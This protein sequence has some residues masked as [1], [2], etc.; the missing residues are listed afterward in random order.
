MAVEIPHGQEAEF[1]RPSISM[2]PH[3]F[4]RPNRVVKSALLGLEKPENLALARLNYELSIGRE[5][6]TAYRRDLLGETIG[7]S[8]WRFI[9]GGL[10]KYFTELQEASDSSIVLLNPEKDGI[11]NSCIHGRHCT[12]VN[13]Y[14]QPIP[15]FEET[16][17]F[18]GE[19]DFLD[20]IHSGLTKLGYLEGTDFI[21]SGTD[22]AYYDFQGQTYD[23]KIELKP[24][25]LKFKSLLTNIGALRDVARFSL[26]QEN[27]EDF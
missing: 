9:Y 27:E 5:P 15:N 11:C 14:L 22:H 21:F 3:H 12:A 25:R 2:R 20:R 18:P 16:N 7:Y 6:R 10:K 4:Y 8:K 13:T 26:D 19:T 24:V 17:P 1:W 23:T